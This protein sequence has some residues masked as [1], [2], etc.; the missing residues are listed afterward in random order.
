MFS[1]K[2]SPIRRRQI[3]HFNNGNGC[4]QRYE[5]RKQINNEENFGVFAFEWSGYSR[6]SFKIKLRVLQT[7]SCV[8]H[9]LVI[10]LF[11]IDNSCRRQTLHSCRQLIDFKNIV[12]L[13]VIVRNKCIKA[14]NWFYF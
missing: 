2:F 4:T 10:A 9:S 14:E 7:T 3:C 5:A 6:C 12:K 8:A 11:V 1:A 13:V